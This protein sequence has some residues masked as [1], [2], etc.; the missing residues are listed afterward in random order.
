[1]TEKDA[2]HTLTGRALEE[3]TLEA[4]LKG[5]VTAEDFRISAETLRQQADDAEAAGY[6]QFAGNLR[7]AAELTGISNEEVL[8]IYTALRPGR[9]SYTTLTALAD[10]LE[11]ELAAPLTAGLVREAAETYRARGLVI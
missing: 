11:H 3:L 10:R 2:I 9:T 6:H 8:A 7:R 4:V 5:E 1:M